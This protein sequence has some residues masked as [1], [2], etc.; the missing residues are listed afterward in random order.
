MKNPFSAREGGADFTRP[1]RK[2]E[3]VEAREERGETGG[4]RHRGA[5]S[6]R[7]RMAQRI[8]RRCPL[9]RAMIEQLLLHDL[10]KLDVKN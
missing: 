6:A 2:R 5:R 9:R 10:Q 7:G 4:A 8:F 3:A 1:G